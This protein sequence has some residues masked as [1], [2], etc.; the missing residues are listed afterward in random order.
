MRETGLDKDT[1]HR[2]LNDLMSTGNPQDSR[3]LVVKEKRG[4][5]TIYALNPNG[6]ELIWESKLSKPFSKKERKKIMR[7]A[8]EG[9]KPLMEKLAKLPIAFQKVWEEVLEPLGILEQAGKE[10][11]TL[12]ELMLLHYGWKNHSI[13]LFCLEK[14]IIEKIITNPHTRERVCSKCGLVQ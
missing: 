1:L 11:I 4:K 7:L 9:L 2:R 14:G 12:K 6:D 5:E 10:S 13:C 3:T 8:S